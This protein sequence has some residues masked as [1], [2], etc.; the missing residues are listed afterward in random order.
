MGSLSGSDRQSRHHALNRL[1]RMA[2][3]KKPIPAAIAKWQL[4][5]QAC[6]IDQTRCA[7]DKGAGIAAAQLQGNA[8]ARGIVIFAAIKQSFD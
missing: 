2:H 4:H 7:E 1:R 5:M 8:L 6:F 3:G